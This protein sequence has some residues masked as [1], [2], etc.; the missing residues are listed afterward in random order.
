MEISFHVR[1]LKEPYVDFKWMDS[2]HDWFVIQESILIGSFELQIDSVRCMAEDVR[3][4][5]AADSFVYLL[6][7]LLFGRRKVQVVNIGSINL[8]ATITGESF[9]ICI[10]DLSNGGRH[11]VC[12]KVAEVS[13]VIGGFLDRL[14][15]HCK[16][17][18]PEIAD[19]GRL[20]VL[21]GY[22]GAYMLGLLFEP[23]VM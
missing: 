9:S 6:G 4:L 22:S 10:T 23:E 13:E 20:G 3:L 7:S 21:A 15:G 8:S 5:E 1:K 11:D 17:Y 16:K 2:Q 19:N 18:L 14:V 12:L